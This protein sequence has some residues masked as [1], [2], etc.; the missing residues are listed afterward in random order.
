[1]NRYQMVTLALA[2][3]VTACLIGVGIAIGEKSPLGIL[4]C[5]VVAF[6]LMG[7]GFSYKRKHM[8]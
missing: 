7:F 2:F 5:I 1:M 8:R 4:G 3:C 6:S